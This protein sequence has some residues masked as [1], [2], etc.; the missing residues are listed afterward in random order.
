VLEHA[1]RRLDRSAPTD[2]LDALVALAAL[3]VEPDG[4]EDWLR[5]ALQHPGSADGVVLSTIHRVKGREW[6]HV[7]LHE[8]SA[9]LLPHRL[10]VDVEEERRVFHVGLTRGSSSVH[11]VAGTP[12]SPFLAEMFEEWT[13]TRPPVREPRSGTGPTQLTNASG[14][15]GGRQPAKPG[16]PRQEETE[17]AAQIG[18]EFEHGGHRHQVAALD[19]GGVVA[20]VG[21]AR[22]RVR[23]GELV[24]VAGRLA[25]LA[26]EPPSPEVVE[27]T[28]LALREWRSE[29]ASKEGKPPFLFLHDRTLEEMAR[30][31]PSSMTTLAQVNGIGPAKLE[32]YGDELLA[33]VASA[34]E[35]A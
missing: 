10:A 6:P 33:I 35:G 19:D 14:R 32:S 15:A 5:R 17:I 26:P 2:D 1:R 12:P 11:V 29:R 22:L 20:I 34:R 3:H 27:R 25:R 31:M 18:L 23:F 24:T 16:R 8:V 30:C 28:R 9:G 13:P 4:F 21:Q 7:V